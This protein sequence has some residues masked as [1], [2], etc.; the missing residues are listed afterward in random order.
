MRDEISEYS[1]KAWI[2]GGIY[3]L[4]VVVLLILKATFSVLLLIFAG[5]LIALFLT[6]LGQL[7]QKKTKW[8]RG[9]S[10]VISVLLT[11]LIMAGLIWL[12]GSKVQSQLTQLS[13]ALPEI[14]Q[15]A[16]QNIGKYS[17][18]ETVIDKLTSPESL[19]K[20]EAVAATFFRSSFGVLGDVYIILLMAIFFTV[21]PDSYK[22]GMISMIPKKGRERGTQII[23]KLANKLRKWL[24]GQ[25]IAMLVVTI[26]TGIGLAII[27]VPM[28][29]AL[30]IIAGILNF[31]PNFG[32]IM[33]MVPA[34]LVSLTISPATAVIVAAL[35]ITVQVIESSLI[36]PNVQKRLIDI[37]PALI[38]IAQLLISPLAGGW[39]LVLATPLMAVIM[40]LVQELYIRKQDA[41]KVA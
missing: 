9:I 36:T 28:W 39:G 6:G 7:I 17:V 20:A 26:M 15:S 11:F 13:E 2:T 5:A 29:L 8:N 32:P 4:I 33:A 25:L 3:A 34:V 1:R 27:G 18:G 41:K 40:T 38:I 37:P 24:K 22:S 31:I 21:S 23:D 35:Y 14:V 10:T 16:R 30:A 12:I 19:K